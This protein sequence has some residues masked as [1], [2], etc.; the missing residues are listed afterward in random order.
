MY[1]QTKTPLYVAF[2]SEY[3]MNVIQESIISKTYEQTKQTISKQD[4][5]PLTIIMESVYSVNSANPYGNIQQQIKLM[6]Q[7]VVVE[8]VRQTTMGVSAYARYIND[9]STT[10]T[11]LG[12]PTFISSVGNKIPFNSKIGI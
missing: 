11:P 7:R 8:C 12:N 5:R 3:N 2:F 1:H 9:I 4:A 10:P 6:N